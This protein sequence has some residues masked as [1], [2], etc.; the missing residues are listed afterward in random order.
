MER[1]GVRAPGDLD[2]RTPTEHERFAV[3][4]LAVPKVGAVFV[5]LL[6]RR[7]PPHFTV[8]PE[9]AALVHD[10][11]QELREPVRHKQPVP[12][13]VLI[14]RYDQCVCVRPVRHLTRRLGDGIICE[15][16]LCATFI[17]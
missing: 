14:E 11:R 17:T 13:A 3:H 6:R 16:H 7:R 9:P 10:L 2:T 8:V 12:L 15:F 4:G 5:A 1:Y